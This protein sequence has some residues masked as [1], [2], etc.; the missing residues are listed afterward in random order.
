MAH[1]GEGNHMPTVFPP[2][3]KTRIGKFNGEQMRIR[4]GGLGVTLTG[5][6]TWEGNKHSQPMVGFKGH[7]ETAEAC[8]QLKQSSEW[9]S[10]RHDISTGE[11]NYIGQCLHNLPCQFL[12]KFKPY[13]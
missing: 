12:L 8:P 3:T 5:K 7:Q 13:K 6:V 1:E 11:V 2:T 9:T 4:H 10:F